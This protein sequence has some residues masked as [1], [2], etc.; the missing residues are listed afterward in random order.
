MSKEKTR[1][2]GRALRNVDNPM[3]TKP[4]AGRF[5]H[6]VRAANDIE[7]TVKFCERALD[8]QREGFQSSDRPAR[9]ALRFGDRK[10]NLQD[11]GTATA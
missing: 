1:P 5:D 8:F 3:A 7:A 4:L 10:I 2:D 9:Y 6:I 11:R